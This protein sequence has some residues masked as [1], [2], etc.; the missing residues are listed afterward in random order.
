MTLTIQINENHSWASIFLS[1]SLCSVI[2]LSSSS[3]FYPIS[4]VSEALLGIQDTFSLLILS[5]III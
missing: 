4:P 2:S 5:S 1:I 3:I